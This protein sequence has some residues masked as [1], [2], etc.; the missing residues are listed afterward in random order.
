M[1]PKTQKRL[2]ILWLAIGGVALVLAV[3]IGPEFF[4]ISVKPRHTEVYLNRPFRL[5]DQNGREVT[6]Q[7]FRNKPT[8]WSF[9]F[10]NCPDVC[11]T[12]LSNLSQALDR[13]GP[14]A[15]KLNV[16]FFTV[17]P[18][19]DTNKVL[20]EY[21]SSFDPR[22]VGL[23]GSPGEIAATAK[24][25]FV[26]QARVPLNDGGYTMEHT[27]K[28]LLTAADGRFAGSIDHHEPVESQV[29]KLR[30]LTRKR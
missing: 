3:L 17:D 11:P 16:V 1:S 22:I 12:T 8:A 6:E 24:G 27:A 29:Q 30:A 25:Y 10:T 20:K 28:V 2:T 21:L 4:P 7:D 13:L 15:D 23:T 5:V 14:D 19:R 9:G 26:H 18:E